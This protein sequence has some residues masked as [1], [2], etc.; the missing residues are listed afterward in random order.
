MDQLKHM[1]GCKP[2]NIDPN[3]APPGMPGLP[4]LGGA[5]QPPGGLPGLG[6]LPGFKPKK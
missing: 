6:G 2:P 1:G 4:G 3:N 5:P